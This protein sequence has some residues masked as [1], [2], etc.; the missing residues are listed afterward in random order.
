MSDYKKI[1]LNQSPSGLCWPS[2]EDIFHLP[3]QV[4]RGRWGLGQKI[5][6]SLKLLIA[7]CVYAWAMCVH[8][9]KSI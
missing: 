1:G 3:L 9:H 8:T 7:S 2:L 6:I 4:V 5:V